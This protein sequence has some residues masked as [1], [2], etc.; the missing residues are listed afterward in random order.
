MTT[1]ARASAAS[2]HVDS[3]LST[4]ATKYENSNFYADRLLPVVNVDKRSG[5]FFTRNRRD[6]NH[7]VSAIMSPKGKANQSSYDVSTDTYSVTDYALMDYVSDSEI[8]NADAPMDPRQLAT[9][10]VT[11]RLMLAREQRAATLLCTSAN[12]TNT[13]AAAA[14]WT[15][16]TTGVPIADINGAIEDIPNSGA[17]S[18]LVA[19]CS[20]PVWNALRKH[21]TILAMK[22]ISGA[23][24]VSRQE[25]AEFF[26]LDELVVSDLRKETAN[27]GQTASYAWMYTATVFGILRI[28]STFVG[29]DISAFGC[30]F[31][32]APGFTTRTWDEPS[33]G[34]G[35][36]E[37]VQVEHSDDE[38]IVQADMGA[39]LTSVIA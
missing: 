17:E 15:N 28:P 19:F 2:L 31:R 26:E 38:K 5:K 33:I 9:A 30:T 12:Y 25:F 24:M 20:L 23:G 3:A 22:G 4:F 35:G 18:K 1:H 8:R 32:M 21:P 13:A 11:H 10:N 39:L 6:Q 14:L 36:S 34:V 16:E 7:V 37:A 29:N 27:L